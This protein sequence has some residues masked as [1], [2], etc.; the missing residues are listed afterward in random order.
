[1]VAVRRF[2]RPSAL[3]C[4]PLH[5]G[6]HYTLE[7]HLTPEHLAL[8]YTQPLGYTRPG[9]GEGGWRVDGVAA[10]GQAEPAGGPEGRLPTQHI[11]F[12][13]TLSRLPRLLPP[14][15]PLAGS[16]VRPAPGSQA[17]REASHTVRAGDREPDQGWP[18]RGGGDRRQIRSSAGQRRGSLPCGHC[19]DL[20]VGGMPGLPEGPAR[21][22]TTP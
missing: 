13:N 16:T 6:I 11:L 22:G 3:H 20:V 19:S 4:T 15:Q 8:G 10:G 1:M 18:R 5:P 7:I 2:I 21:V 14:C 17:G 12:K 9:P